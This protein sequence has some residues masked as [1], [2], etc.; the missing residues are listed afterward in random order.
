[1]TEQTSDID[2][3]EWDKIDDF[4]RTVYSAGDD[5][6]V[7]IKTM[8]PSK[9]SKAEEDVK[10]LQKVAQAAQGPV[11]KKDAEGFGTIAAKADALF[12]DFFDLLRDVPDEL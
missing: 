2:K 4:L 12:E 11:S 9:Q 8:D 10:L 1:V 3:K 7:I 6:K 5:M